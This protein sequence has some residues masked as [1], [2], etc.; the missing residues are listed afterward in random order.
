MIKFDESK[1]IGL[2]NFLFWLQFPILE[3]LVLAV[4]G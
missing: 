4:S 1:K 3:Y 2:F